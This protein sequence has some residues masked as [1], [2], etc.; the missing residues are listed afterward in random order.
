MTDDG[1]EGGAAPTES[2]HVDGAAKATSHESNR[3]FKPPRR[4]SALTRRLRRKIVLA[5]TAALAL[6]LVLLCGVTNVGVYSLVTQRADNIIDLIH[7]GGGAFPDLRPPESALEGFVMRVTSETPFESRYAVA[8]FS[9]DGAVTATDL[10]HVAA[11]DDAAATSLATSVLESGEE[12]GYLDS[13]RFAVFRDEDGGGSVVLL[14]SFQQL[15]SCNGVLLVSIAAAL[16]CLV[17]VFLALI[18]LSHLIAQPFERNMLR[19]KRFVT[20]ASHELKTPLAIIS[21]NNDLTEVE[22]GPTRWTQSTRTQVARLEAL[23]AN[24]IDLSRAEEP[25]STALRMPVDV[26]RVAGARCES[27]APLA[28]AQGKKIALS[29]EGTLVIDGMADDIERLCDILLDNAV[30]HSDADATITVSVRAKRR[31]GSLVV[32]NPCK[33]LDAR[34]LSG[35]FERFSRADKSRG[36]ASG[37]YGIGLSLAQL[38][39]ERHG[40]RIS[41]E[42]VGDDVR[43]TATFK[44]RR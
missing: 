9:A 41:A 32:S 20:D 4:A 42:K 22:T 23:I 35:L 13:Y 12:R 27:F 21:A 28:E 44:G 25:V 7:E 33:G 26:G 31:G 18:P 11:L 14:D 38:I 16:A 2:P 36:R 30:R 8:S 10:G 1:R 19:Q 5:A 40:G 43:F 34:E 3:G 6:T 24:L 39:V 15:Q 29:V 17:V 37:G